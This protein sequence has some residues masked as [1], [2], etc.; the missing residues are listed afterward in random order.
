ML[1]FTLLLFFTNVN[2][3]NKGLL[4]G[5]QDNPSNLNITIFSFKLKIK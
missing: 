3:F 1:L 5:G 4:N 2:P